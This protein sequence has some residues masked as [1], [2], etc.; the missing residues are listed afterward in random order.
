MCGRRRKPRLEPDVKSSRFVTEREITNGSRRLRGQPTRSIK[1]QTRRLSDFFPPRRLFGRREYSLRKLWRFR[2]RSSSSRSSTSL[3]RGRGRSLWSTLFG[4]PRR[5]ASC[6]TLI[7]WLR[8]LL[9][10][11]RD[12]MR[13]EPNMHPEFN[14][15]DVTDGTLS[16]LKLPV[17]VVSKSKQGWSMLCRSPRTQRSLLL[18]LLSTHLHGGR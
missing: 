3:S 6:D 11:A 16:P 2:S 17:D 5:F 14:Q 1:C 10:I 8:P 9:L 15:R 13:E 4:I 12:Y 7:R 18:G